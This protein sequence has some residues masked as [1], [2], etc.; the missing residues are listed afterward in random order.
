MNHPK[1]QCIGNIGDKVDES[2]TSLTL[3]S[4]AEIPISKNL[5]AKPCPKYSVVVWPSHCIPAK[6]ALAS[7][8]QFGK[9]TA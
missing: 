1:H 7:L 5:T 3:S 6:D 4:I 9:A 2:E 8:Q